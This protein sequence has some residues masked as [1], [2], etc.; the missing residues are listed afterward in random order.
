MK[1]YEKAKTGNGF[2]FVAKPI[3]STPWGVYRDSIGGGK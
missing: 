3:E 2:L 1:D